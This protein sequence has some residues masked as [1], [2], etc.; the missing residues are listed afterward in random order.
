MN[1]NWFDVASKVDGCEFST[2]GIW[3]IRGEDENADFAGPHSN[4]LIAVC[5]G[6]LENVSRYAITLDDFYTWGAGGFVKMRPEQAIPIKVDEEFLRK[7]VLSEE[8]RQERIKLIDEKEK[9]LKKVEQELEELKK[10]L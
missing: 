1:K 3:E 5:E 10:G 7:N 9:A 4:P 2:Y 6:T 8:Q